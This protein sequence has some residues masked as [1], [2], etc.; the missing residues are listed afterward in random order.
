MHQTHNGPAHSAQWTGPHSTDVLA[1][2]DDSKLCHCGH[3]R[4]EHAEGMY[5]HGPMIGGSLSE[6]H[7]NGYTCTCSCFETADARRA[8]LAALRILR[9]AE[10]N[11]D[12]E[13]ADAQILLIR[14][15]YHIENT[16]IQEAC[17]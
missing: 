16:R 3:S 11:T 15:A 7:A 9:Q 12:W 6:Q 5:C 13:R 10:R 17:Q 1:Q 14:A 2:P 4:A 8:R